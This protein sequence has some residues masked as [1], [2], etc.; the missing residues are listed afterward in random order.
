MD[1]SREFYKDLLEN[2]NPHH[3]GI[4]TPGQKSR[5]KGLDIAG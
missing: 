2:N 1:D 5:K 3:S 4:S